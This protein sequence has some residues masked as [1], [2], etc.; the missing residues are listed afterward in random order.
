MKKIL[1]IISI[2][3]PVYLFG[4]N[5]TGT[6]YEK[7]GENEAPIP[8]V[9]VYWVNT[10][11]GTATNLEGKFKIE[12]PSKDYKQLV[13]SYVGYDNDT[14]SIDKKEKDLEIVL[15]MN[16]ELQ[17]FEVVSR[18]PGAH[19]S[20]LEAM[21]VVEITGTE[22]C[23]AA[24]CN[25]GESFETNASVDVHYS[26]AVTGAKQ[27]QL[28]GLSGTYV[29]LMT[30]NVPNLYGLAQP[31]GLSYIPGTWMKSISISKGSA[32]VLD[33]F[34]SLAGQINTQTKDPDDGE[35]LIV[36]G[37][38]NSMLKYEANVV[39]R[40]KITNKLSTN[41]LLH[42]ENNSTAHDGNGDGFVDAP[43]ITQFNLMNKWKYRINEG[44]MIMFG[45]KG[46][47]EDRR[48][49]Q[50]DYY[51]TENN[52][53]L[54]GIDIKTKRLEGLLKGGHEF[55]NNNFNVALK[56]T[57]SYHEQKSFYGKNRYDA[58]QTSVYVNT[59]F[60]GVFAN[61]PE[62]SFSTGLSF[63]YDNYVEELHINTVA[64]APESPFGGA[65]LNDTTM[66]TK[67]IVPGAYFQY[68]FNKEKFPTIIAGLR[69]DY[70]NEYGFFVTPRLHVRY[71]IND[72]NI[73]RA[74]AGMG[75]KTPRII[76]ENTSLL[77]SSKQIFV[78][79]NL[80]MEKAWNYGINYTRYFTI[81]D[82]ELVLNAEVY[83]SDF[84]NQIITD[85][86]Q[87][88]R[89]VY[90]YNLDG[91]SYSNVFQVEVNYE[92]IRGLDMVLAFRYQD[93]KVT[94][95]NKGL[96]RKPMVNRYK[97]LINLSY[98]TRMDKWRFDFTTQFNG[99]QRLP[100]PDYS[101]GGSSIPEW[102]GDLKD[103]SP[104]Y[105]ILNAQV[106][107]NFKNW[108]VYIGGENLT[109]YKQ[110]NPIIGADNPFSE[111]FDSSRVWGPIHGIMGYIGFRVNIN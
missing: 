42:A 91:K 38:I 9:N 27:I 26:D 103:N 71:N 45:I 75:Y 49:G 19:I 18:A 78:L 96:E 86:D 6:V 53:D 28:L 89:F 4:Q 15:T 111:Y 80:D 10:T 70:H 23:K 51:N 88:Y 33:G 95:M 61:N 72:K 76:S 90:F 14:I 32:A 93:V 8:G 79:G 66:T 81:N 98:G 5:V 43:M 82:K 60:Q 64:N 92:L 22:L 16:K 102:S 84:V 59:V 35:R 3:F 48:G 37:L 73:I 39:T 87:D 7:T 13:I 94:E 25:L 83:R 85:M 54:Y 108:S 68:T 30:E 41:I 99:D 20:R 47:Y 109:N 44:S 17:T 1:I 65:S 31:Y 34:S 2:I 110:N 58:T 101:V 40:F 69:G 12:R 100:I 67:E 105:V 21:T 62:H 77:A 106:T 55:A 29:Q 36:N 56:S 24:C 97:G 50:V 52:S 57:A 11:I 74:S 63:A 107:K 104:M 46:L